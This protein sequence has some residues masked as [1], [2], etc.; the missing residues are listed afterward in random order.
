M[1]AF[2]YDL[3]QLDSVENADHGTLRER[4]NL[5]R[6]VLFKGLM[7]RWSM[8]RELQ[9]RQ[10]IEAQMGL[11]APHVGNPIVKFTATPAWVDGQLGYAADLKTRNSS[12]F[13]TTFARFAQLL[14]RC[15]S[16]EGEH[17]IYMQSRVVPWPTPLAERLR[18]FAECCLLAP[19]RA[20]LWIGS[21]GQVV[22]LHHDDKL[23]FMCILAGT[24]RITLFPPE[25]AADLYPGPL[26]SPFGA[27][28]SY[29]TL[30]K[31]DLARF[32][33]FSRAL[34]QAH[35]AMLYPGDILYLPPFWWHH[36]ESFG[37]NIMLNGWFNMATPAAEHALRTELR[38]GV[39][40]F[41]GESADERAR[42][43]AALFGSPPGGRPDRRPRQELCGYLDRCRTVI[44]QLHPYWMREIRHQYDYFVFQTD[45]RP[46]ETVPGEFDRM[47]ERFA[48]QA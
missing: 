6:P 33:R 27:P 5:C 47:V 22:N 40:L 32:P 2:P 34:V 8:F 14:V 26:D 15:A 24:K 42:A 45:G 36:V 41:A 10:G 11:L 13:K 28:A 17:T 35:L 46:M 44:S 1:R 43:R 23:N 39:V 20:S 18:E 9:E 3:P 4:V 38:R 31:P 48:L 37:V 21:G 16:T 25:A 12:I 30:L 29:V 7:K 19:G